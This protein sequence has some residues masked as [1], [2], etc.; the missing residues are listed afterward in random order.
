MRKTILML[1][2][3]AILPA[4][5]FAQLG[6]GG[7]VLYKSPVLL[8]QS[9]DIDNH[10]VDQFSLGGDLRYKLGLLQGEGLLLYSAGTVNSLSAY[11]DAGVVLDL[12]IVELSLGVGPNFNNNFGASRPVQAGFNAKIGADLML[13]RMSVGLT[14]IMAMNID[15]GVDVNTRSGLL[16]A[17]VLF[18]M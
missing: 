16:G 17:Q 4:A 12:A 15:N 18:W 5:I 10:N 7:A 8:G 9:V 14:Y 6:V 2:A 3:L 1:F 13:G 11:L